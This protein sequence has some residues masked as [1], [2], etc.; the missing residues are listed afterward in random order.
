MN[1]LNKLLDNALL[2]CSLP[3]DA[4]LAARLGVSRSAVS[5]WRQGASIKEV[6]L[7]EVVRLAKGTVEDAVHVLQEQA[8]TKA[9]KD[10]WSHALSKLAAVAI[11]IAPF[12]AGAN[13]KAPE[14]KGFDA[15]NS[16]VCILC[17]VC[18][19]IWRS[20]LARILQPR[21]LLTRSLQHA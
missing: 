11:F 20:L 3:S 4:Q 6:H 17:S 15:S 18:S 8:S 9:S 16:V 13:E 1:T 5:L 2:T 14:I 21:R 7:A 10:L 12:A 19:Y